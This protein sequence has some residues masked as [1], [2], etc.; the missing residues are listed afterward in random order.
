MPQSD[1]RTAVPIE[2]ASDLLRP[3]HALDW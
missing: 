1:Q 3:S 2:V